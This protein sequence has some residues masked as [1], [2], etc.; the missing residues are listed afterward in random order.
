[1]GLHDTNIDLV[2]T[3]LNMN[4]RTLQRR[5]AKQGLTF[6]KLL[7]DVRM[8]TACWHLQSSQLDITLLSEVLGYNDVSAFSKAF[9]QFAGISPLKWRKSAQAS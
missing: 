3:M 2:A 1:M 5:L 8:S 9:K 6:K 7:A 4:R